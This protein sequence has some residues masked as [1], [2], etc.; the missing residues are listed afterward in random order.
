MAPASRKEF[1]DIQANY[2]VWIHYKIVCDTII[3]YRP[4]LKLIF[5]KIL[6]KGTEKLY[7]RI[8]FSRTL[9]F[10]ELLPMATSE[11]M[12]PKECENHITQNNKQTQTHVCT[13]KMSSQCTITLQDIRKATDFSIC[14]V[15]KKG[16][17]WVSFG[18]KLRY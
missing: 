12:L 5:S 17:K 14:Q 1:F 2:R 15:E 6:R 8:A 10:A 3:I 18:A 16:Q 11:Y 4:P 7:C 9:I 13:K